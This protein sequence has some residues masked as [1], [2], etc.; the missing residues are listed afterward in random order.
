[1]DSPPTLDNKKI[2]VEE[3]K[4]VIAFIIIPFSIAGALIRI[5]LQRLEVYTGAPVFGLVYAQWIG[6][7]VMGIAVKNKTNLFYL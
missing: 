6:C 7:F 2:A 4:L 5:A 1:M 3:N